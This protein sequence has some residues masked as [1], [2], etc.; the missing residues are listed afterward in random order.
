[1]DEGENSTWKPKENSSAEGVL[2]SGLNQEK[3]RPTKVAGPR[4]EP[5]G[6]R[7]P[8]GKGFDRRSGIGEVAPPAASQHQVTPQLIGSTDSRLNVPVVRV[9]R[10]ARGTANTGKSQASLV[11]G[12]CRK[13]GRIGLCAGIE[14]VVQPAIFLVRSKGKVPAQSKIQGEP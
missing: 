6:V 12:E 8:F 14:A 4:P 13:L 2:K 10:F 9:C 7:I 3:S 11:I 5:V 1:M